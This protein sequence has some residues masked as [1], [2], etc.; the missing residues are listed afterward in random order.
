M[1]FGNFRSGSFTLDA[2]ATTAD[3][4]QVSAHYRALYD[5]WGPQHWW[6]ARSRFEVIVGAYLTQNTSWKNVEIALRHLRGAGELN[7]AAIRTIPLRQLEA[8]IR[9][10]GYFRQKANRLKL[11]V[12]FVD[13][14]YGGSLNRLFAQPT[15]ELRQQLLSLKGVGPET[16]D[17]ILLY[18]GQHPVFVVDTYARR[19]V[20]RHR[21]ATAKTKYEALRK[22]FERALSST[23]PMTGNPELATEFRPVPHAPSRM[24][25][26]QRSPRAQ[27]YND[28]HGLIVATGKLYCLKSAPRCEHCP[29]QRFLP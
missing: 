4:Q 17:S 27:A 21:I 12:A 1:H 3:E 24:S 8:M 25:L 16:A 2:V 10:A 6:P 9:P 7:L 19:I 22:L 5:A 28:M 26:V 13:Q 20:E 15:Q 18:A 11:F 14:H 29:L 23:Q